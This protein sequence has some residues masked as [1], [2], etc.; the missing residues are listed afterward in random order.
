MKT[1]R[2]IYQ[3]EGAASRSCSRLQGAHSYCGGINNMP[4]PY[5]EREK[6]G[7]AGFDGFNF[8]EQ[9][10]DSFFAP[11]NT[12]WLDACVIQRTKVDLG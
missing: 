11:V 7:Q 2:N 6:Y 4:R 3:I 5:L 9:I 8:Q 12:N 10:H 1:G